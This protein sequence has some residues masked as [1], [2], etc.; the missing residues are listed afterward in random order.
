MIQVLRLLEAGGG[1]AAWVS[2]GFWELPV[3]L[4][5]SGELYLNPCS[6]SPHV[7]A[8]IIQ[9]TTREIYGPL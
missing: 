8:T 6:I 5:P 4:G 9:D 1:T 2:P 7:H 3:G